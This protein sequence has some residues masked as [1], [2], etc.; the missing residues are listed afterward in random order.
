MKKLKMLAAFAVL[1][2]ALSAAVGCTQSA[3]DGDKQ[4]P[5]PAPEIVRI[6]DF[7]ISADGIVTFTEKD[8]ATY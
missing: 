2:L 3:D 6:E 8:G 5:E 1:V 7:E 4:Q